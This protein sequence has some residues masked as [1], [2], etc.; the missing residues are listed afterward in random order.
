MLRSNDRESPSFT[1]IELV[2]LAY[3]PGATVPAPASNVHYWVEGP[4]PGKC[5]LEFTCVRGSHTITHT[6]TFLVATQKSSEEWR[7]EVRDQIQLQTMVTPSKCGLSQALTEG[8]DVARL[9]PPL[10]FSGSVND[11]CIRQ[12][13]YYYRELFR[14]KPEIFMWAGMAKTAGASVYAGMAEIQIWNNIQKS[15]LWPANHDPGKPLFHERFPHH[16]LLRH[17]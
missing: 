7:K 16:C 1:R 8:L 14:E 17:F 2:G 4:T 15:A 3:G 13:Y 5:T 12:F 6:Q 10:G 9:S 11:K